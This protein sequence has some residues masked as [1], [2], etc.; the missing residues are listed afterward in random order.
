MKHAGELPT[1]SDVVSAR[2]VMTDIARVTPVL[3]SD[4]LDAA[5]GA[6][7]YVKA[8]FLQGGGSFKV[9]GIYTKL[10]TLAPAERER[11][12]VTATFGNA[13]I[14][15]ALAARMLR[16]TSTIVMPERPSEIKRAAIERAGGHVVLHGASSE[17]MLAEA[18]AISARDGRTF[19]HPFDQPEVIAGQGTIGLELDDQVAELEAILIPVGGGGMLA[20]I[21]LAL[22]EL[23]PEL[24]IVG[25][26]PVEANTVGVAL[27]NRQVTDLDAPSTVAE[28]LA[29][30][31]CGRLPF[32]L[33]TRD[34]SR[35][36]TVS[37]ASI[38]RA[39]ELL[40]RHL[41]VVVEPAGAVGLAALLTSDEFRGK[42]VAVVASGANLEPGKLD[43]AIAEIDAAARRAPA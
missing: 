30:K 21:G 37:D 17:E 7:V 42:R 9:R 29:V 35:V 8:E 16:M 40:R 39:V 15:L 10:A 13:G 2:A 23:R 32:E 41:Q 36:V 38:M 6:R 34:T 25:V 11:G 14:A 26:E 3:R 1:F 31:R 4:P 22:R 12:V 43:D 18:L 20:G 28:G 27:R 5:L 24:E 19:V 33:I